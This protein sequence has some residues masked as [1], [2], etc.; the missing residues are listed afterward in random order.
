VYPGNARPYPSGPVS[1]LRTAR[2][3]TT[4]T[5]NSA[6]G[7]AETGQSVPPSAA[8]G[9]SA[10]S[11][12]ASRTGAAHVACCTGAAGGSAVTGVVPGESLPHAASAS[13]SDAVSVGRRDMAGRA[14]EGCAGR[15]SGKRAN[16]RF[17]TEET[18]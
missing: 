6:P 7:C 14:V 2:V 17:G 12:T 4:A 10:V 13:R 1:A 9:S 5:T 8:A 3:S 16:G 18:S 15:T 11:P